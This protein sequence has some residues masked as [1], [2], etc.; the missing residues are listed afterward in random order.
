MFEDETVETAGDEGLEVSEF[1]DTLGEEKESPKGED[2]SRK[3]KETKGE[4]SE[5][6][7]TGEKIEKEDKEKEKEEEV[8]GEEDKEEEGK[9]KKDGEEEKEEEVVL[10]T[11][12]PTFKTINEKFPTLFKVFP[13]LKE[14]YFREAEY[15]KIFPSVEEAKE[16]HERQQDYVWMEESILSGDPARLG[17][18]MDSVEQGKKGALESMAQNFLPALLNT[19]RDTYYNVTT[20]FI[21]EFLRSIY[22]DGLKSSNDNLK[23]SAL[24][25]AKSVF[26]DT[27]FVTSETPIKMGKTPSKEESQE[28]SK[29]EQEKK[30]YQQTRYR[31]F[32]GGVDEKAKSNLQSIIKRGLDPESALTPYMSRIIIEDVFNSINDLMEKDTRYMSAINSLWKK[33]DRAGFVG[34]WESRI[35]STY[36]ER[37]KSLLPSVRSKA[38]SEALGHGNAQSRKKVDDAQK[39]KG[40]RD[41]SPSGKSSSGEGKGSKTPDASKIDWENTSDEDFLNDK[42]TLRK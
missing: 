7:E 31:D 21:Q 12:R 34:E 19:S 15:T 28:R 39:D 9:E 24:H 3:P 26:G 8:K 38:M 20:P 16:V 11:S 13:D 2:E 36:L 27:K 25:M 42:I 41:V 33:A 5:F 23:N 1:E 14:M 22:S 4:V 10:T 18:F 37:A 32:K 6:T 17:E 30:D 29:F 40:R 35:L